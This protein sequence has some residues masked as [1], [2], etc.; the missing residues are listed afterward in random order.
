LKV[1]RRVAWKAALMV[2]VMVGMLVDGM[3][4]QLVGK[5]VE[6]RDAMVEKKVVGMVEM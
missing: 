1:V 2:D 4:G 3:V 5:L 6:K